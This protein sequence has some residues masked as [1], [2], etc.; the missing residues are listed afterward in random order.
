MN[1]LQSTPAE[2]SLKYPKLDFIHLKGK[3]F[4][5]YN[6][7]YR[8]NDCY[9]IKELDKIVAKDQLLFQKYG[10]KI[11]QFN[12]IIVDSV[13]PAILADLTLEVLLKK[14]SSFNE[15]INLKKDSIIIS[16]RWDQEFYRYKFQTFIHYFAFSNIHT[17][18]ICKGEI[19][20]ER[21]YYKKSNDG[22]EYYPIYCLHQFQEMLLGQME[23]KV[24]YSKSFIFNQEASICLQ[25]IFD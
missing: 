22:V 18:E 13:F 21:V 4:G 10:S 8:I 6:I 20:T 1:I 23:I 14:I 17:Q 25:F 3:I 2:L 19:D 15:Y 16:R 5:E 11:Q 12:I 7:I 24:D 9:S